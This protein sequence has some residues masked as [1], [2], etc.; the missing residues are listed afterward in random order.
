MQDP[1]L[2][3][4]SAGSDLNLT[5]PTS[6]PL[7]E[8]WSLRVSLDALP[9]SPG[10]LPLRPCVLAPDL[11]APRQKSGALA[12]TGQDRFLLS[13]FH[14]ESWFICHGS[15]A[16][17]VLR[18][19]FSRCH[20]SSW[21]LQSMTPALEQTNRERFKHSQQICCWPTLM[22]NEVSVV[23]VAFG[24]D[25]C[26]CYGE[27]CRS[28]PH[29]Y[30]Y[31]DVKKRAKEWILLWLFVVNRPNNGEVSSFSPQSSQAVIPWLYTTIVLL[32]VMRF[33]APRTATH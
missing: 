26:R 23:A 3:F 1:Q 24:K 9:P 7:T 17:D 30:V 4:N 18:T 32:I 31:S 15:W 14:S 11:S 2:V 19:N 13:H 33:E 22:S 5:P 21:P 27:F 20:S 8:L 16:S 10:L 6:P 25:R 12:W 29:K 28:E